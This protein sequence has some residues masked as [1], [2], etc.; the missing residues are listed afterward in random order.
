MAKSASCAYVPSKDAWGWATAATKAL[1]L[2]LV[3]R[4]HHVDREELGLGLGLGGEVAHFASFRYVSSCASISRSAMARARSISGAFFM[5]R[6]MSA[7]PSV[8]TSSGVSLVMS[9]SSRM[10]RSMMRPRLLPTAER[11]LRWK[12]QSP[13][14]RP[15]ARAGSMMGFRWLPR[16]ETTRSAS[17]DGN[18]LSPSTGRNRG[19]LQACKLVSDELPILYSYCD[20]RNWTLVTTRSI[21]SCDEGH[22][23]SI[24]AGDVETY[25]SGNFKGLGG[26]R[27]ERMAVTSRVGVVHQCPYETGKLSMGIIYAVRTLLQ[28]RDS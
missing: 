23:A 18:S 19:P 17:S 4:E 6:M 11:G 15:E 12:P 9:R 21:W 8:L 28:L 24:A 26:R 1:E 10:G 2:A 16:G 22:V 14:W 5:G 27:I 13:A 7:S 20:A 25:T 3:Q